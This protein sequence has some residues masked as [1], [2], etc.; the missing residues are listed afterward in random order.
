MEDGL[1]LVYV[2]F[3]D[4]DTAYK[5]GSSLLQGG[6]IACLNIFRN[7]TSV[8]VWDGDVRT[9]EECVAIMKTMK[10]LGEKVM[11]I[12]REQHPYEIPA[13]F[14]V[15]TE[16]CSPAFLDWVSSHTGKTTLSGK[17]PRTT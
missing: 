6:M 5:I 14:S 9:S 16:T 15:N 3:P 12:I 2:T 17:G 13:L 7:V 11:H 8:Y 4:Y 10:S 1:S